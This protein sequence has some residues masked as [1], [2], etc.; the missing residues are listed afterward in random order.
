MLKLKKYLILAFLSILLSS[1]ASKN[2][3]TH[4][5]PKQYTI[6]KSMPV[7]PVADKKGTVSIEEVIKNRS[8]WVNYGCYMYSRYREILRFATLGE[9]IIEKPDTVKC[10]G[11]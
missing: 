7:A 4:D 5:I 10:T 1:C 9:V 8:E 2:I 3:N 6:L 11:F